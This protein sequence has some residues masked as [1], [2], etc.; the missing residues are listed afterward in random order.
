MLIPDKYNKVLESRMNKIT[1]YILQLRDGGFDNLPLLLK[2]EL[3]LHSLLEEAYYLGEENGEK[4][5]EN[6]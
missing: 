3:G 2:I 5:M 4:Q 6:R 1:E